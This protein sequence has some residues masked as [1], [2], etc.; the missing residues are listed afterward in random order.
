MT[1][2]KA[3]REKISTELPWKFSPPWPWWYGGGH[4]T[5]E[6]R[7]VV[8]VASDGI[9]NGCYGDA[10]STSRDSTGKQEAA[11]RGQEG[12]TSDDGLTLRQLL[13][14]IRRLYQGTHKL[15]KMWKK[16]SKSTITKIQ[17]LEK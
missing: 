13:V 9:P 8:G 1:S 16:F 12:R 5:I 11:Q 2:P 14:G 10:Q 17:F 15:Q 4:D 3:T 7:L 6:E